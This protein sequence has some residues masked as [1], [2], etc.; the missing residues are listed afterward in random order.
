MEFWSSYWWPLITAIIG[1]VYVGLLV[2]QWYRR[3]KPHQL[4]WAFGFL[5][6]AVAAFMEFY[7]PRPVK[8]CMKPS[9]PASSISLSRP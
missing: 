8:W 1:L 4:A 5:L 9:A 2:A 6:Y 3:R 7:W